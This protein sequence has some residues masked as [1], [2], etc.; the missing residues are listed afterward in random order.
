MWFIYVSSVYIGVYLVYRSIVYFDKISFAILVILNI[1]N[2]F[3][4]KKSDIVNYIMSNCEYFKK[5][6]II[7][8]DK[9][10]DDKK[11]MIA[12]YFINLF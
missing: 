4:C 2:L 7:T 3:F 11:S 1:Y 12:V 10:L 5:L 6:E 9:I 8:E